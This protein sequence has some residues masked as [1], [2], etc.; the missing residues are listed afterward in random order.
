MKDVDIAIVM[1]L[2]SA[3]RIYEVAFPIESVFLL[4]VLSSLSM[5]IQN[6]KIKTLPIVTVIMKL[7]TYQL[8]HTGYS[9]SRKAIKL[10]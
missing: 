10:A 3:G 6:I 9:A 5:Q 8:A 7:L 1:E 4:S 2:G